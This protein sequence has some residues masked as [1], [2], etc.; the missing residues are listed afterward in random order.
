MLREIEKIKRKYH[1]LHII[2]L[3]QFMQTY[4]NFILIEFNSSYIYFNL[5][6]KKKNIIQFKKIKIHFYQC[7]TNI[8]LNLSGF[9]GTSLFNINLITWVKI[10]NNILLNILIKILYNALLMILFLMS[11]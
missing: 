3:P 10:K 2:L 4:K 5:N 9:F 8:I 6:M 11:Y 7:F 1:F